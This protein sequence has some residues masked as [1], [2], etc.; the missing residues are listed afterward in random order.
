MALLGRF[1][2]SYGKNA[3]ADV[4]RSLTDAIVA[5]D[6]Q[7]ASEAEILAI[8]EQF[9]QVNR[10]YSKA[11]REFDKE[12]KEADA[13]LDLRERR[14]KAAGILSEKAEAGDAAAST[15]LDKLLTVLEGMEDDIES[16]VEE[17]EDAK[18]VMNELDQTVKMYADKL[19]NARRDMKKAAQTMQKAEKQAERAQAKAERAA[20]MAGIKENTSSLG[21]ALA[22][23]NRQA[24]EKQAQADA[25]LRKAALLGKSNVEDDDAVAAAMAAASG[26]GGADAP[27]NA[28]DRLAAL[29]GK[30]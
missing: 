23:M 30:R 27:T 9:D 3:V 7:G 19:K 22:S 29:R 16:E 15:G 1:L 26:E 28:K 20:V 14:L 17:A 24:E 11:K 21:S 18:L 8:E 13:I 10:E 4:S 5:F 6:P 2:K 12:Q 25:A